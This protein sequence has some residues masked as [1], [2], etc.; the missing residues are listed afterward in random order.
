MTSRQLSSNE[1]LMKLRSFISGNRITS[2]E[3]ITGGSSDN[4]L[5]R[6]IKTKINHFRRIA[7]CNEHIIDIRRLKV[8][9][10]KIL[11]SKDKN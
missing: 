11:V 8:E 3:I 10:K 4:E 5:K 1:K 7:T 9:R 2:C 6:F